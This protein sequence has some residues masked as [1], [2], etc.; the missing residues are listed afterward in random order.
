MI[1]IKTEREIEKMREA[2]KILIDTHEYAKQLVVPGITTGEI[3][4]KIDQF[5]RQRGGIPATKG[6]GGFP[7]SLCLSI[8]EEVVHGI[9]GKRIIQ[10]GDIVSV[11]IVVKYDGYYSDA[12]RTLAAGKISE[13]AERLIEVTKQSFFEGIKYAKEGYRLFDISNAIQTFVEAQG[14]SIV[15]DYVGHGIG[16]SMHEDP[17]IPNFGPAN[18][19]PRLK[20]G[21]V[22][23]IEPMVNEGVFQVRTLGDDW[24]VVTSDGKLSAHYEN[25]IVITDGEPE[26]LT[27]L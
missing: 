8:N 18:R 6:Y 15:R 26:I 7:K 19:G 10:E 22:L 20:K 16:K 21:M 11:D 24:T 2:S 25:T 23:A 1:Y 9:P 14:F 17:Q 4:Q 3:D 12:A 13:N 5:I 27:I